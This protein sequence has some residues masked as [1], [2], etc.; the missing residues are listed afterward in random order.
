MKR[1]IQYEG[2]F[3]LVFLLTLFCY[4]KTLARHVMNVHLNAAQRAP[5]QTGEIDGEMSLEFLKRFI[6]YARRFF[7]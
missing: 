2:N 6:G 4:F 7:F 3:I 5:T 1:E